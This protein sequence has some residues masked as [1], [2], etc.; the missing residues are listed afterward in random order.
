MSYLYIEENGSKI[1]V[2]SN[3]VVV[4]CK[5]GNRRI[6][7]LETLESI[8]IYGNSTITTPC[9]MEC[10]KRGIPIEYYSMSGAYF[11]KVM[12]TGHVNTARQRK[13]CLTNEAFHMQMSKKII[14]AKI[15]NQIVLVRRYAKSAG[16]NC[17][18]ELRMM[19]AAVHKTETI[20]E[21]NILM[22]QEGIAARAY[23]QA[24]SKLVPKEF[25][26]N[27]RSKRPPKD[28]FNSMISL[29]YSIIMNEIYGK[30]EGKGLNPYF[31]FL[32]KD[33]EK[34]PAL[35][36]DLMEEWRAV[37]VDAV[38]MSLI[39]GHE[40]AKEH[41]TKNEE[42]QGIYL[43]KEGMKRFLKKMDMKLK[44]EVRYLD[45]AAYPVSFRRAMDLQIGQ[46]VK[47]LEAEDAE[48]YQPVL[49]R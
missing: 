12:S 18:Q 44:T 11:G 3:T 19:K 20:A 1:G 31:G 9:I 41:F 35:A 4:E 39:N 23:F 14:R 48:L 6:V 10:I 24:L 32:H 16:K 43:S 26:F 45:Y 49:I 33:R 8:S 5:A 42:T 30:I 21:A 7:P 47:A 28:E 34:H 22:G 27:G 29:G 25:L 46:Y 2:E 38:A 37:L 15:Q 17:D 36:S 13:Q 40:I